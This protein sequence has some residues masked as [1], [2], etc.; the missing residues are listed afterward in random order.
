RTLISFP[1]L[2]D[3]GLAADWKLETNA[4]ERERLD[5]PERRKVNVDIGYLDFSKVVLLSMKPLG[6]KVYL[7]RG[8]YAHVV[9]TYAKGH[10]IPSPQ[11]FADFSGGEYHGDLLCIRGLLRK[12]NRSE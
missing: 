8:V 3:P 1:G 2:R 5:S 6:C 4:V 10:Y 9:L 7:N 11:G 12:E